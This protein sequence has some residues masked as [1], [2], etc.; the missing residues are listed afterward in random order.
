MTVPTNM[1]ARPHLIEV[2]LVLADGMGLVFLFSGF[3]G[4]AMLTVALFGVFMCAVGLLVV[5]GF[6]MA[7][8][9]LLGGR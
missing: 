7:A 3:M 4:N 6:L 2:L 8:G 5:A 1:R 9:S